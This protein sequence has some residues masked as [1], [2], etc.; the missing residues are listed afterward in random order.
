MEIANGFVTLD[1][2][3]RTGATPRLCA[4]LGVL[5]TDS[6]VFIEDSSTN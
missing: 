3:I 6:L 4:I 1:R 5:N 2:P